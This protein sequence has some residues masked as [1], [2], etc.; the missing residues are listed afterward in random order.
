MNISRDG[1]AS[2]SS[3]ASGEND[4]LF[5]GFNQDSGKCI[6][7]SFSVMTAT[8]S[9]YPGEATLHDDS[10]RIAAYASPLTYFIANI[11][12]FSFVSYDL[13]NLSVSSSSW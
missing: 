12:V 10:F 2:S 9:W 11:L 13:N 8:L 1:H 5:I 4:L 7:S 3:S 6:M